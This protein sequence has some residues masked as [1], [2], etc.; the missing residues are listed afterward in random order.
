M[1]VTIHDV[2][3][4]AH[5]EWFSRREGI[6][7][8]V[9]TARSARRA[10]RVLTVS[11]FSKRE[12]VR[13]LGIDPGKVEVIYSGTTALALPAGDM[14]AEPLV[15][16]VGSI[17]TR[18][19]VPELVEGFSKLALRHPDA[20]LVLVGDNRTRPRL[21]LDALIR[22]SGAAGRISALDYVTGEELSRLYARASAFAF[23][24]DYEGFGLTPLEALAARIPVVALD[25][26]VSREI[27]GPAAC[28]VDRPAPPLIQDALERV[29]YDSRERARLLDAAP[30]VLG[31]YDWQECAH[32]TL[33]ALLSAADGAARATQFPA[34]APPGR[35]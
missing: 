2:S 20:R 25:T 24:S 26:E 11:D 19:H 27:Y 34:S 6:R 4:A 22:T 16:Y 15:L 3:F 29:L 21:D 8:R 9:V 13:H 1:V 23:L 18:R 12:I 33:Q 7:R 28:Y 35:P 30:G 14:P 10:R 32:R 5:P 17:F 31:R